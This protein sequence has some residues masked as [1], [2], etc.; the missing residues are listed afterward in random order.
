MHLS[1]PQRLTNAQLAEALMEKFLPF[2]PIVAVKA[3][4]DQRGRP[5]GFV[6]YVHASSA[7]AVLAAAVNSKNDQQEDLNGLRII[8]AVSG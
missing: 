5:F 8:F 3:S 1:L 4:R 6:E 2:G 7:Q